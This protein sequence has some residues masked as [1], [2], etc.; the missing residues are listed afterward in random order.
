VELSEDELIAA[1]RRVLSG[2]GPEVIVGPGDDAAVLAPPSGQLVL[3]ADALIE[4]VHFDLAFTSAR[5]L[6]YKAVVVNLSDIAAMGASPRAAVVTLAL[7]RG[8]E[9]SWVIELY[10]GMREACDEHALWLVGGDLTRGAQIAISVTVAGDVAPGR[11]VTRAGGRPGHIV[12][13]T[14]ELGA[15]AAGLRIAR[16]G[17]VG[18]ERDRALLLAH[19]RPVA[20]V[21]EGAVLA[22]HEASAMMDVSDGLGK[23]LTRLAAASGVRARLRLVDVPI[24]TGATAAEGLGGGEDYELL[25]A[26]PGPQALEAAATELRESYG[27]ALTAIGE[28]AEGDGVVAV[29]DDGIVRPLDPSGWD[30]FRS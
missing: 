5:D 3:T 15:S 1:I 20:R 10:G 24:A 9:A 11:A 27:T 23:D 21:G 2:A 18:T 25:V 30:H 6:G 19:L 13:V 22:R 28:L 29:G 12:A 4:G 7:S 14:G 17:R 26:L 8:V 16:A